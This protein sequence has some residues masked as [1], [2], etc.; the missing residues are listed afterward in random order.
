MKCGKV[1]LLSIT[2]LNVAYKSL[3]D[4]GVPKQDARFVLPN[5]CESEIVLTANFRELRHIFK[6]RCAKAAQWEIRG[7]A[8]DMLKIMKVQAPVVFEDFEMYSDSNGTITHASL[9]KG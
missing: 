4:H 2:P 8:L 6:E 3:K 9:K 7:I 5:A 1:E